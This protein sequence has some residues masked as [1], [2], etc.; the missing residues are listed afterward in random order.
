MS[1]L[2]LHTHFTY[3]TYNKR[4]LWYL[5][6][7]FGDFCNVGKDNTFGMFRP[8]QNDVKDGALAMEKLPDMQ[9]RR[10]C[11]LKIKIHVDFDN[12]ITR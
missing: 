10:G 8:S 3:Y 6:Y 5:L 2:T 4:E 7:T 9:T 12:V 11:Y 1:V